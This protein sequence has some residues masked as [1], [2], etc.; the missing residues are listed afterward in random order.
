MKPKDQFDKNMEAADH[1]LRSVKELRKARGLGDKGRLGKDNQDLYW[2]PRAAIVASVSALDAYVHQVLFDIIPHLLATAKPL[3]PA[4]CELVLVVFR[5]AK[6][7]QV[8]AAVV[9][10][11]SPNPTLEIASKIK[12]VLDSRSFQAPDKFIQ[13]YEYIGR[14]DIF[15]AV[16]DR[17]QGPNSSEDD[18]K[19]SLRKYVHRRNQIAHEGDL[20]K[21]VPRPITPE[22]ASDCSDFVKSLVTRLNDIVY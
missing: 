2:Q 12:D 14:P 8:D 16:A 17:W 21:G 19:R 9:L 10:M 13:A 18:L 11:R 4:L 5:V 3:P 1:Y 7:H 22:Y 20:S 15:L 6:A